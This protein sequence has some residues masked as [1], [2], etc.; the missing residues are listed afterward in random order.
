MEVKDGVDL[1]G[2]KYPMIEALIAAEFIWIVHGH[3]PEGVTVTSALDGDHK[4]GSLHYIGYALDF[5]SRYFSVAEA[6]RIAV[7]LSSDLGSDYD[8]VVE[9]THIHC[10]YQ[11]KRIN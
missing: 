2:L 1:S 10:E 8:V 11:P 5:R 9:S 7:I 4:D 3:R 6:E